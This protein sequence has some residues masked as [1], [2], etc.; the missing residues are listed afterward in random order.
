MR[1]R[2]ALG[3]RGRPVRGS[4]EGLDRKRRISAAYGRYIAASLADPN[5]APPEPTIGRD[6][7]EAALVRAYLLGFKQDLKAAG[8]AARAAEKR[9][10][11]DARLAAF[12]AQVA[13]ALNEREAMR[14]AVARARALDPDDPDVLLASSVVRGDIDGQ[15]AQAIERIAAGG[16]HCARAIGHLEHDRPFRIGTR[17]SHRGG[18]GVAARDRGGSGK[19]GCLRQSGDPAARPKPGRRSG[20]LIDKALELDPSFSVGYTARGRYWIQKGEIAKGI[21]AALA[22]STAN[23]AYSQGLL[24]TALAY[25]QNGDDDLAMQALDN[26]DRLDPNDPVIAIARTAIAL[27]AYQADEAVRAARESV[28]RY[29][30]RGGDYAGLAV[31]R[32]AGSYPAQAYR[33]LDLDEWARFYGDRVFDPFTASS[34]FDQAAAQRQG[35]LVTRPT[36]SSVLGGDTDL[37][38][39]ALTIQGLF[40]DPLAVSSRVGRQDLLRR[41][42]IDTEIGGSLAGPKRASRLG[43]GCDG[44]GFTNDPLPTSFSIVGRTRPFRWTSIARQ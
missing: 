5:A 34:Y 12:S 23:P 14:E 18:S 24:V 42:F 25:F 31:N 29:R 8:V 22:G 15:V 26:A 1:I 17:Q 16:R 40:F 38:A 20:Q 43:R 9:F 35:V 19:P 28:R 33:F 39:F 37:I 27:D 10:P 30:L 21:E 36:I 41:P 32:Q 4:R 13:M 6:E 2:T 44:A 11:R 7:P 3:R